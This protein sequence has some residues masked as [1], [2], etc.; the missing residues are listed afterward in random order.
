MNRRSFLV[1]SSTALLASAMVGHSA[2]SNSKIRIGQIGTE[3]GHASGKIKAIRNQPE[4]YELV[5]V[6]ESDAARRK[7]LSN[8]NAFREVSWLSEK[9]L[10]KVK[11][12]QAVAIETDLPDLVATAHRCIDAGFHIHLDKPGGDSFSEYKRLL[13]KAEASQRIVQMGYMLRYN[14]AFQFMYKAVREGWLGNI[15]EIDCMMGKLADE[16]IRKDIGRFP[17]GGMFE[18]GGHVIDSIV[19]MLGKPISVTPF[20][21]RTQADGVADNQVAVLDFKQ[22]IVTVRINHMDPNGFPRRRF[23]IAG[24]KGAI[25]IQQLESGNMTLYLNQAHGRYQKGE[26]QVA[27]GKDGRYDGEFLDL[28]QVMRVEKK[29]N[30]TYQHDL[31]THEAL[32]KASGMPV[33]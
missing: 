5:G 23:Q 11:G 4:T 16:R 17:G 1:S 7:Q 19:H 2:D 10:F 31:I 30:W 24:D 8:N 27:L 25:E 14:R 22:A 28:A 26:Q 18:L 9:E 20:T 3:H 32:L 29:L 12:L 15:M 21:N 33:S 13:K 6:V